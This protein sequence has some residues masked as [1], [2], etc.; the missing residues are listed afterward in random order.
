MAGLLAECRQAIIDQAGRLYTGEAIDLQVEA[1]RKVCSHIASAERVRFACSGTD[2]TYNARR[3]AWAYTKRNM[4]VRFNGHY[5]G[6]LD[7]FM[8]GIVADPRSPTPVAG[9]LEEDIYSQMAN[10]A[11]RA[12]HAFSDSFMIVGWLFLLSWKPGA[13]I[14]QK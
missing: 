2:A 13:A 10:T 8:G 5:H 12:A 4:I 3:A 14:E 7:E 11:G 6:G 1:A 9:E